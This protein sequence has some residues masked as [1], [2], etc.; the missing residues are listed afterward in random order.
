MAFPSWSV[1]PPLAFSSC[2][3][4]G[5]LVFVGLGGPLRCISS[6]PQLHGLLGSTGMQPMPPHCSWD[7]G[8]GPGAGSGL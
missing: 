3:F 5:F 6:G 4:V 8:H 7:L 1:V 2:A